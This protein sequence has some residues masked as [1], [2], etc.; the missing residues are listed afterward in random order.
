MKMQSGRA[1]WLVCCAVV[2]AGCGDVESV[3]VSATDGGKASETESDVTAGAGG[4]A[5]DGGASAAGATK[6]DNGTTEVSGGAQV[7]TVGMV[8]I[9]KGT[10]IMGS[11]EGDS[12]Q[13]PSHSV[14]VNAFEMDE[15]E[16][17]VAAYQ[18]CVDAGVCEVATW[19]S[20]TGEC[21][22]DVLGRDEHPITCVSQD[23]ASAYCEWAGKRLPTEEEWEYAARGS[24]GRTYPW[25]NE[26][27]VDQLCWSGGSGGLRKMSCPVGSFPEGES[28]FGV[29]DMAG[30]VQE[31][32]ASGWSANYDAQRLTSYRVIRGSDW[33]TKY[34]YK[35]GATGRG[36]FYHVA[37]SGRV[38]FRCARGAAG[39]TGVGG[40]GGATGVGGA[41]SVGGEGGTVTVDVNAMVSIPAGAFQMGSADG[42]SDEL[43]VRSV[44]LAAFEIDET[45]VT[46]DE[47]QACVAAGGCAAHYL[48][49]ASNGAL[50]NIEYCNANVAGRGNHPINCVYWGEASKYC[51]WAGKRLPTEAEWEYAARG[52]QSFTYPWGEAA[53]SG[54]LCWSG[55]ALGFRAS[56][57]PVGS[58]PA[59]DSPFGVKDMAGNVR[60]WT[61]ST[62]TA[63]Y[64]ST[65]S[66]EYQVFRGGS[67]GNTDPWYLRAA[68]RNYRT[69]YYSDS[70]LGF[71][72]AR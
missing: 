51:A 14:T 67:W 24:D 36:N 12:H 38:G 26:P 72:C 19:N 49:A 42:P 59:G 39:G 43:P 18:A 40:A 60:E 41:T 16:V 45:E 65:P 20:E 13:L 70:I 48:V 69:S 33:S 3:A 10:F 62:W 71:R 34:T 9:P 44:S 25:G 37:S 55:D 28:P 64:E 47:Y 1:I 7:K 54:Q 31:W 50:N 29:K 58:F 53:P 6:V 66:T 23:E 52:S 56:T 2:T 46:V 30:N 22:A 11:E 57:C 4:T 5:G 68:F 63:T 8:A 61:A 21:N 32:T 17:T 15:T 27:P 35:F